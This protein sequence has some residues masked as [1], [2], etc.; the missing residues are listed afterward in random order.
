[1]YSAKQFSNWPDIL[2]VILFD[3]FSKMQCRAC[4]Y[5]VCVCVCV[6]MC[7]H[8]CVCACMHVCVHVCVCACMCSRQGRKK[9]LA[10]RTPIVVITNIGHVPDWLQ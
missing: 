3:W 7:M 1:M 4:L 9:V 10:C 8:V 2:A 6:C 5:A